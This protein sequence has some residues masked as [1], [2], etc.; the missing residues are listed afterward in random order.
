MDT[1]IDKIVFTVATEKAKVVKELIEL[2]LQP[3]P[4]WMPTYLWHWLIRHLLI[5]KEIKQK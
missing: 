1:L 5:I 3:K 2:H 4:E